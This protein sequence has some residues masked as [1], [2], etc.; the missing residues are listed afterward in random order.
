MFLC[1]VFMAVSIV[2]KPYGDDNSQT[3][4]NILSSTEENIFPL[5]GE[6]VVVGEDVHTV[7]DVTVAA[8]QEA[9]I[10]SNDDSQR[11][12]DLHPE[13][14]TAPVL[15]EVT[16]TTE[17]LPIPNMYIQADIKDMNPPTDVPADVAIFSQEIQQEDAG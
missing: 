16:N 9:V 4:T 5:A 1:S 7:Q 13:N 17:P 3:P 11:L 12:N 6:D 2:S 8:M 15:D 14:V 10:P